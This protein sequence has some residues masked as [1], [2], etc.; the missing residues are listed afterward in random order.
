MEPCRHKLLQ[1]FQ[2]LLLGDEINP[3]AYEGKTDHSSSIVDTVFYMTTAVAVKISDDLRRSDRES[4]NVH[5]E[6]RRGRQTRSG[7]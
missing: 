4:V 7:E 2:T 1:D 6:S 5:A 3:S